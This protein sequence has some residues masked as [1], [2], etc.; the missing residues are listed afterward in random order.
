M[1]LDIK[2]RRFWLDSR[3]AQT[4]V[5]GPDQGDCEASFDETNHLRVWTGPFPRKKNCDALD[6]AVSFTSEHA[7][8]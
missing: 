4:A 7:L 2:A 6:E 1:R 5:L 3:A 8:A